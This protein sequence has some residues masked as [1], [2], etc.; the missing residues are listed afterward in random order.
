MTILPSSR[1]CRAAALIAAATLLLPAAPAEAD[2]IRLN[3]GGEI[4][5]SVRNRTDLAGRTEVTIVTLTGASI[6]VSR[7]DIEF[8]TPRS[9]ELE[10][11]ENR[12][13]KLPD[14]VEAHWE[15]AEWCRDN[16]LT[17]QRHEQLEAVLALDPDHEAAHRALR[18]TFHNGEWL[19]QEELMR[20]RGY[21]RHKNR[22]VTQQELDLIEKSAAEREA[23]QKW[24]ARVRLW[25]G[26]LT[27]RHPERREEAVANLSALTDPDAVPALQQFLAQHENPDVRLLCVRILTRLPGL[28]PL[29]PLV[30]RSLDDD[31]ATI[32]SEAIAGVTPQRR[33][34]AVELYLAALTHDLNIIVRRAALAL[35]TLGSDAEV[36][37]LIDA[38]VTE[39]RYKVTV[40][41][42]DQSYAVGSDGSIGM[43]QG[44]MLPPEVEGALRT[45][46]LPYGAVVV[47][48]RSAVRTKTVTVKRAEKNPEVRE[49]L[50]QLT[51]QDFGYDQRT[52]HLWWAAQQSDATP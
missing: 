20:S 15:L 13:R 38:L 14:T 28:K 6:V 49:T 44:T 26:W 7:N 22:W 35:R 23:E 8:V 39:H 48:P 18:H 27:G 52:W 46:Q 9:L 36:D 45:G 29:R 41:I 3:N 10:I 12:V 21:I 2:L 43:A 4:R 5:G 11:Y 42:Q 40:R 51:D 25:A 32:R 17:R 1:N 30:E 33:E 19:S 16:R 50:K 47:P 34:D 37:E 31:E 24:Y